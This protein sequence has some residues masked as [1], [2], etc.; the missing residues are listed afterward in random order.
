MTFRRDGNLYE[1]KLSGPQSTN[2]FNGVDKTIENLDQRNVWALCVNELNPD[3]PEILKAERCTQFVF[4]RFRRD[5][6]L[7]RDD[8]EGLW[9]LAKRDTQKKPKGGDGDGGGAPPPNDGGA[10]PSG[11]GGQ[12]G[13]GA[14]TQQLPQPPV[15]EVPDVG[16]HYRPI[17]NVPRRARVRRASRA[18]FRWI[19]L[20]TLRQAPTFRHTRR[21]VAKAMR[22]ANDAVRR[23]AERAQKALLLSLGWDP[24]ACEYGVN[25]AV[26][27]AGH[28]VQDGRFGAVLEPRV[29]ERGALKLT[30][31]TFSPYDKPRWELWLF[32]RLTEDEQLFYEVS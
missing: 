31:W 18:A 24:L 10:G 3:L 15:V 29:I 23:F 16:D 17:S 12:G 20:E 21:V 1:L 7:K 6:I 30:L 4:T 8:E 26:T 2:L 25:L 5:L 14:Q 27:P 19:A 13:G 9:V 11:G 28:L 22:R 32:G